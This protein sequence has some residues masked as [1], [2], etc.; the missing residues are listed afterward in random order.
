[1]PLPFLLSLLATLS[2]LLAGCAGLDPSTVPGKPRIVID[3][4]EQQAY[5]Y[6]GS[7]LVLK[8]EVSTGRE[9]HTTP[10]GDYRV[11]EKSLDHRSTVYGSYVAEGRVVVGGVDVRRDPQP[12]GTKYEGAPMPYFLRIAGPIGLHAGQVPGYPASHGCI[13]LPRENARIF[14]ETAR[15]GTPV[16]V[17]R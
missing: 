11:T 14:F 3:L 8:S 4:S 9:G 15:E 1:M 5:L 6:K 10:Q 16:R 12:P 17:Q 13:R 7:T 2:L